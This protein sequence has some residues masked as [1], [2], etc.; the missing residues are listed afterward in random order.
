MSDAERQEQFMEL[1]ATC[2][3]RVMACIYALIHNM[4]DTEDVYQE[5]CMVMWRRFD[6]YRPGTEFVKW[7]CSIAYLK[8]MDHLRKRRGGV[9]FSEKFVNDFAVWEAALPAEESDPLVQALYRCIDRLN[10]SDRRLLDSRYWEP[11]TVVD[12]AEELGRSPQSV[13]NS[14]GRIR[15]QLM[16]CVERARSTENRP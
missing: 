3:P 14:L 8:V 11:R 2:Q 12:I 6:T 1:L 4:Q 13:C 7:A 9:C 10:E 16:E 5:A 15:A